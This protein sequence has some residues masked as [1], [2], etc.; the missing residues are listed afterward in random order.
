MQRILTYFSL[1]LFPLAAAF[2]L[3]ASA[4]A[5]PKFPVNVRV[6]YSTTYDDNILK[7]SARDLQRFETNTELTPSE[8]TTTD[9]W[10]NSFG[11]R[12]YADLDISKKIKFR[13]YYSAKVNLYAVNPV[14]NYQSHYFLGRFSYRYRYYL[15][16]QYFYMPGYYLRIYRDRDT[17]EFHSCRF[18]MY[19]PAVRFR[20]RLS[21]YEIEGEGGRE[22]IYYNKFFTEYDTEAYFLGVNGT[23]SGIQDLTLSLGYRFK[24][25]D[26]IGFSQNSLL[27]STDPLSDAEYGDGTY[28]EDQY[29]FDISYLL[30]IE[31]YWD[32]KVNFSFSRSIRYYQS[33]QSLSQD[34]F[35]VGRKDRRDKWNPSLVVSPLQ[36][37]DL[38]FSF[39]YDLRRTA[40][41]DPT[42]SSIKNFD[43]RVF[44]VTLVYQVY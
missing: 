30:P 22:Y 25:A 12:V 2:S 37:L 27:P 20:Y 9:D 1:L 23:Y 21:P 43:D 3:P 6:T 26:N 29:S 16:L 35:H 13:P 36:I 39:I 11:L 28:E 14:N 15:F 19:Q 17:N 8:I 32:W 40:S 33:T 5:K 34:P 18:D 24:S 7:Y 31:F 10:V 41:P 44:Q 38:E 42:V 4:D